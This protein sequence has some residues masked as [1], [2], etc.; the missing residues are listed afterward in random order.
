MPAGA[1]DS[2]REPNSAPADTWPGHS[3]LGPTKSLAG[4]SSVATECP[5]LSAVRFQARHPDW[6]IRL[7]NGGSTF[8]AEQ[9]GDRSAQV[10]A[11]HSLGQL[12]DR[13][14]AEVTGQA[15]PGS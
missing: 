15:D 4:Y 7:V 12:M 8:V 5:T 11:Y 1:A 2:R 6:S 3:V 10:I 14:E 9:N 13:L